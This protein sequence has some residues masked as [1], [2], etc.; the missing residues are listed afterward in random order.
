MEREEHMNDDYGKNNDSIYC[1]YAGCYGI[2]WVDPDR[3]IMYRGEALGNEFDQLAE[4]FVFNNRGKCGVLECIMLNPWQEPKEDVYIDNAHG[5]PARALY[6]KTCFIQCRY[7][8]IVR[9]VDDSS[10]G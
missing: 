4:N 7:G 3:R 10:K 1:E 5:M 8:G 6:T 9:F 2:F